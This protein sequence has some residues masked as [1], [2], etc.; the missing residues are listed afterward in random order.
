MAIASQIKQYMADSSWIRR[1]F[2]LGIAMKRERGEENV[3]DLSLGNPV[4]E[5][6]P[7]FM[8]EMRRLLDEL[9]AGSHRYM[10]NA[11]YV[12]TRAAV[13]SALAEETGLAYGAQH[14]LMTVGAGGGINA[15]LHAL[16]EPDDE[17]VIFAPFF[18]EYLFYAVN[19]GAKSVA[20]GC[21]ADFTPDLAE[22]EAKITPRTKVVMVN[23]PNNPSGRVY[24]DTFIRDLGALLQRKG[25]E[26]ETEIYLLSDEPYRKIIFDDQ[27]YPFPQLAYDKTITV[28]SHSKDL[29][30]PGERIGYVAVHPDYE[31]A[32][33]L[34][35]AFVFCNRVLGFVNAPAM[36]QHV[37]RA[38]QHV[39]VD[40]SD[41]QR[42]RDYLY[43][44]LTE[45]GYEVFKPEGAFYMFPKSPVEDEM[46]LV[47]ALQ[48]HGVLV[49]PG[50]GFGMPGYFRISYCVDQH[51][52]EG[53][54]PGFQA[55]A[56]ELGAS[57]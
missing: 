27:P 56:K 51:V 17:V 47:E 35:D 9:P 37:V 11:G 1:M 49:V 36:M 12:E 53:A 10:P 40:V 42:K 22:L 29:A 4:M 32:A 33:E 41:Y 54:V 30:L 23:S 18:A 14:V 50:R 48:R 44:V 25:H 38:L 2:E 43:G 7:E 45:A 21:G 3:F 24:P 26:L 8:A 5:P 16:C 20:V 57:S 34:M 15:V 46:V 39:T 55:V 31:G 28:T 52:L 6:P 13:A 19:H